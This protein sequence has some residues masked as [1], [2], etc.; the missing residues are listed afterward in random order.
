MIVYTRRRCNNVQLLNGSRSVTLWLCMVCWLLPVNAHGLDLMLAKVFRDDIDIS[1]WLVSEKL[2]GVRGFWDGKHLLSKN[3]K[4]LSPP[5]AFVQGLPPF[6]LEGEIWGGRGTFAKT[7]AIVQRHQPHAGWLGLRF[8]VF[9]VPGSPLGFTRRLARARKWFV[10]HPSPYAFVIEQK[11]IRSNAQLEEELQ[12]VEGLGGEGLIVRQAHA[13]YVHG[14]SNEILKV[15]RFF[16][17]EAVV[18]AHVPGKGKNKGR[19]GSLLV[20]LVQDSHDGK[21]KIRCK[22][23][24]GFSDEQREHPPA[25]GTVI[26]FKYYGFYPS[27]QPKFPSFLRVRPSPL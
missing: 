6:A 8:A 9:D 1:G 23:G 13:L 27:G 24:T 18:I 5:A 17:M 12:R 11:I 15:K 16:D 10:D 7:I 4:D 26:T 21:K 20:E 19:L 22:I 3:G 14:R 2:D 25:I